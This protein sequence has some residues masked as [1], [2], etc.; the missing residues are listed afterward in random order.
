[1]RGL[2]ILAL[3]LAGAVP[4]G[5][6]PLGFPA[7]VLVEADTHSFRLLEVRFPSPSPGPIPGNATVWGHLYLPRHGRDHGRPPCVLVLPVMAAPNVW[8][9]TRFVDE[10]VRAGFAVMWI[11]MPYQ[12]H[13]RPDPLVPS[14]QVFLSRTAAGL[15]RNF[16]QST[17]DARRALTWLRSSGLVDPDRIGLFGI[18][19]GAIVGASVYS[20]DERPRAAVFLLG[21]A[22]LPDLAFDG[23]MTAAFVRQAGISRE[24][25]RRQWRGMDPVDFR[26]R[27]HGKKVELLNARGDKVIPEA[28][29]LKLRDA[30]PD[31]TQSWVPFGHYGAIVHLSWLPTMV[32][33]KFGALLR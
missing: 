10:L 19:L 5:S 11:E 2:L 31:S 4:A 27:N 6:S 17:E 8:I 3:T 21:G 20:R 24:E 9:E 26:E 25:L 28:N 7:D 12:F 33:W 13:R 22:D 14:G 16:E 29:A 15:R 23:E 1:M 30:F 32:A 18:S